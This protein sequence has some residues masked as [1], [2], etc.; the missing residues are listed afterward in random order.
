MDVDPVNIKYRTVYPAASTKFG[1]LVMVVVPMFQR[2]LRNASL[3]VEGP[4]MLLTQ[5]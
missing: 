4:V 5:P 2:F 3:H 1:T